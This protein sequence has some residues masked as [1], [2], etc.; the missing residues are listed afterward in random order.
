MAETADATGISRATRYAYLGA[1]A[2]L[3]RGCMRRV[4]EALT[5]RSPASCP[6]KRPIGEQFRTARTRFSAS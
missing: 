5:T 3:Y 1:K 6:R 2:E 4:T